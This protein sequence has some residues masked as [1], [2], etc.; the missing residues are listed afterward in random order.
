[1]FPPHPTELL[2][3]LLREEI[4][5]GDYVIDATAG[6]GHDTCFLAKCVGAGGRVLAI[7]IQPQAIESTRARLEAE[8]LLERV[9]LHLGSH[10]DLAEIPC[11][12]RPFAIIF[13]LGYLPGGDRAIITNTAGTLA[14]L[15]AAAE[16][17]RPGGI[18][19]VICYTAHAGGEEEG[20]EAQN[21]IRSLPDFRTARY[22]TFAVEKPVPFLLMSRKLA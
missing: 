12:G 16:I 20:A 6:N 9:T 11:E 2:H 7:D 18:L 17:L 10:A 14:A 3:L 8:G 15:A 19:A 5:A 13:N 22:G 21:F 1:M 4:S